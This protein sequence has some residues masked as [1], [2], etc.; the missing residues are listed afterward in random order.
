MISP[1]HPGRVIHVW[2]HYVLDLAGDGR[3]AFLSLYAITYS[4]SVGEGHVALLTFD[5]GGGRRNLLLCD[6]LETGRRMKDRLRQIGYTRSS[7]DVEPSPARFTRTAS[8]LQMM[9]R[10]ESD[11]STIVGRWAR[12]APAFLVSAPAP[13]LVPDEDITAVF[14]EAGSGRLEVDESSIE[15]DVETDASWIPKVGRPLL[16]S[17]AALAEVR[18]Q[19]A[20]C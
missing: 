3:S 8:A 16:A 20:D 7:F 11:H 14:V 4:P 9:W 18:V 5:A 13:Q 6:D 12:L 10:I 19:P 15:A 1:I 2:D 17:H